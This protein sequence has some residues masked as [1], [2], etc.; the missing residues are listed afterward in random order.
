MHPISTLMAWLAAILVVIAPALIAADSGGVLPWTQWAAVIGCLIAWGFAAPS[1]LSRQA[2]GK[3]QCHSIAILLL[4]LA[5]YGFFQAAPLPAGVVGLLAPGS[6]E[7]Y[8]GWLSPLALVPA[9]AEVLNAL[10]PRIS[11]DPSLTRSAAWLSVLVAG[12][13]LLASHLFAQRS[14]LQ[15]LLIALAV[16]GA[17]QALLGMYQLLAAPDATVWG[18]RSFLGGKPFGSFVNRSN[19]AV[20]LNL[21]LAGS[22]GLIAWRLAALTGAVFNGERFP[23]S[24][25]LDLA[26]DR[27]AIIGFTTAGL[28]TIG[29]LI[30]GSRSGLAGLVGGFLLAIGAVQSTHKVRGM[31]ATLTAVAIIAAVTM[32]NLDLSALSAQRMSDTAEE[33][34]DHSRFEDAR[35]DHWPDALTTLAGQPVTGWGWGA[36]RY[37]YLPFQKSHASAWFINADNLWIEVL[38]EAGLIG[39]ALVTVGIFIIIRSLTRLNLS[40]NP[41][42]HGLVIT[43]WFT[44]GAMAT[45]QIFD[46]GLRIPANSIM[47][48]VVLSVVVG[49]SYMVVAKERDVIPRSNFRLPLQVG[50]T[51]IHTTTTQRFARLSNLALV[52]GSVLWLLAAANA[53]A[54]AARSDKSVRA[55]R[56]LLRENRTDLQAAETVSEELAQC[57]AVNP[58]HHPALTELSRL[59]LALARAHIA[60]KLHHSAPRQ[61]IREIEKALTRAQ[62]RKVWYSE[63]T[64][65][66][67]PLAIQT[68]PQLTQ[69]LRDLS[70]RIAASR[71]HAIASLLASPLSPEA[72]LAVVALDYASG[73]PDQSTQ[74]LHQ[75]ARLRKHS[76]TTLLTV[77]DFAA[78]A[79]DWDFAASSWKRAAHLRANTVRAV[80]QRVT[81]ASPLRP[82]DVIPDSPAALKL[83]AILEVAQPSP[84]TALLSRAVA[85][86]DRSLPSENAQRAKQLHLIAKLQR[87]LNR[88]DEASKALQQATSLLPRDKDLRWEYA[89]TLLQLSDLDE[90]ANQATTGQQLDPD[91]SRFEKL[92]R[93]INLQ[94]DR[95]RD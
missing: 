30:C 80:L 16:T 41:I 22:L 7:V 92:M 64:G 55:A 78:E 82:N 27:L 83:A 48:A 42:D 46:F 25:L 53:L 21:G 43:G 70:P 85:A 14:R 35:F 79:G 49:R 59:E 34:V 40:V 87:K 45:S 39:L 12:F 26:F 50:Q 77:G 8:S 62:L 67:D 90:A 38:V 9:D 93:K 94:R 32:V 60:Q 69:T 6:A 61:S 31:I 74:L 76:P 44:L 17:I 88:L 47:A 56:L 4:A 71:Q 72:R 81:A 58:R 23:L 66:Q 24:Q 54:W 95:E 29:L 3:W 15:L 73:D 13:A 33:I 52:V 28:A 65:N 20:M 68:D 86:L 84:D 91:D 18:I 75:V 63:L 5:A 57:V 89:N 37:A 19:A 1:C 10:Q 36:Y 2:E 11:V 51:D